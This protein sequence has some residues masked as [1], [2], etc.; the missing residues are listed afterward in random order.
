MKNIYMKIIHN[1]YTSHE[2]FPN[3]LAQAQVTPMQSIKSLEEGHSLK[4]VHIT[5]MFFI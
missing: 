3:H 5:Q 4:C 2:V 1:N